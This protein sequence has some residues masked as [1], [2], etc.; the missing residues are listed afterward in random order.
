M[1]PTTC[2]PLASFRPSSVS[3]MAE[4][5]PGRLMMRQY[6]GSRPPGATEDGGEF[7]FQADLAHLLAKPGHLLVRHGQGGFGRDIA[8]GRAG[9]AGCQHQVA[10]G[11]VH[12]FDQRGADGGLFVG[13]Q[14]RLQVM[15]LSA[16]L[17]QSCRPGSPLSSYT[18]VLARS[19]METMPTR[20][21][22]I[23]WSCG[24]GVLGV[25]RGLQGLAHQLKRCR[26]TRGHGAGASPGFSGFG[27][28][29][30]W[31]TRGAQLLAVGVGAEVHPLARGVVAGNQAVARLRPG[32]ATPVS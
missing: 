32:A 10:A 1:P 2:V 6:L 22:S 24:R 13:D 4:G 19:L 25:A 29:R 21:V 27:V 28:L 20:R 11:L 7:E 14:A 5:W 8:Q 23:R 9:A 17:S 30:A 18:P 16:R 26:G 3:A 31:R 15:G 12:Q